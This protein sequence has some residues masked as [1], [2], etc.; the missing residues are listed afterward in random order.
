MKK[1]VIVSD[2]FKGTLSSVDIC[3]IA[4]D[5]F[6]ALMPECELVCIPV[7]DG[8]EGSVDCFTY[9]GAE[10][11]SVTVSDPWGNRIDAHYA[12]S[13]IRGIVEMAAAAGLPLV[14]SRKN[15][16]LTTTYG[17]GEQ[18]RCAVN[19]G[20]TEI[21]LGL[22]GSATNDGG[23]GCAAALGTKFYRSDGSSFV[24]VGATLN[25]I[26]RIDTSESDA[27]L[28]DVSITLMCDVT[29]PL[30]GKN[31]AAYI[32]APQ[33]GA[34]ADSVKALDG[35]LK[36]LGD[37]LDEIRP[38]VSQLPGAG[39]AGGM[40]AGC[41]A[42]LG[43][44]TVSGIEAVLDAVSFNAKALN[45]DM[46]ISGEG[47]LDSQSLNGKVISGVAARCSKLSLPLVIIAGCVT[48]C[49]PELYSRGVSA[50]FNT[51]RACRRMDDISLHCRED[52]AAALGD[53]LRLVKSLAK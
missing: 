4:K 31:G 23:C 35:G 17:V 14:G 37:L 49:T 12:V 10:E 32:F 48:D 52:Y 9:L 8:G 46:V 20:C 29:N 36:H 44:K 28:K 53:V 34:D 16:A 45:A 2:S 11:R 19:D 22:G 24:P 26:A 38:G 43:A 42:L 25:E 40:G 39:A 1:C 33:K 27:F 6:S 21:L 41:T 18:I 30:Y 5:V 3:D 47:R 50:V 15:P 7:A 13:G 51:N